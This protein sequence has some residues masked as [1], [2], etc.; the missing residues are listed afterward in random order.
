MDNPFLLSDGEVA[1]FI[2]KGYHLVE[3]ELPAGLNESIANQLDVL[4]TTPAMPSP[5]PCLNS[6]NCRP[7]TV[8]GASS[9][10]WGTS[11]KSSPTATGT[12]NS[13][14]RVI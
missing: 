11:M 10:F 4:D 7:P 1:E 5:K 14:I 3:P 8:Q 9:A 13:P 12:A 2:V 6:G